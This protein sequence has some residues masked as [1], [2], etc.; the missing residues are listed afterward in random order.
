[1]TVLAAFDNRH[2]CRPTLF[3]NLLVE[4]L[5]RTLSFRAL[6]LAARINFMQRCIGLIVRQRALEVQVIAVQV[7]IVFIDPAQPGRAPGIDQ[8]HNTTATS[9]GSERLPNFCSHL[10]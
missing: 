3:A 1:M 7:D 6:Q 4:Q 2:H 10:I 9:A 8:M 5:I